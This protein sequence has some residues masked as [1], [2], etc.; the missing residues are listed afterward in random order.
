M[1]GQTVFVIDPDANARTATARLLSDSG[2]AVQSY[3]SAEEFLEHE[4]KDRPSC[5]IADLRLPGQDGL[6]LFAALRASGRFTPIILM[7]A[8]ADV[9]SSVLAMKKGAVDFLVKPV[10]EDILVQAVRTALI[11]DRDTRSRHRA[12]ESLRARYDLLTH[13]EAEVFWLVTHGMLNKQIARELQISEQT[14]K[15]HRR[16]VMRKMRAN[17]FAD[18][19]HQATRLEGRIDP[20]GTEVRGHRRAS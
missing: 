3:R 10:P 20:R 13:R 14:V 6:D 8:L 4:K 18:L 7:T 5:V 2:F 17:S 19:V 16:R 11:V 12:V 15:D 1:I 9:P